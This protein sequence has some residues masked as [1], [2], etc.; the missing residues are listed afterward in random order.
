MRFAAITP[1]LG[2]P[3]ATG[4]V[5]AIEEVDSERRATLE[6]VVALPDGTITLT[7][8]AVVAL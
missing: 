7:G 4:T 5:V 6:L 2:Q 3:S 8:D 1:V